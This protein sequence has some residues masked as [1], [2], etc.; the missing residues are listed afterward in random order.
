M[1]LDMTPASP[2][3]IHGVGFF[4]DACSRPTYQSVRWVGTLAL[5]TGLL[6]HAGESRAVAD[7]VRLSGQGEIRGKVLKNDDSVVVVETPSGAV[8]E[9]DPASVLFVTKRPEIVE[10]YETRA[11]MTPMN[12]KAQWDLAEWCRRNRLKDQRKQ[13]LQNVVVIEPDHKKARGALNHVQHKGQWVPRHQSMIDKGFVKH[14][15]RYITRQELELIEKSNTQIEAEKKWLKQI[16]T[17]MK[18]IKGRDVNKSRQ[19]LA[20]IKSLRDPDSIHGLARVLSNDPD[21]RARALYIEILSGIPGEKPV[22]HLV[23]QS[24]RDVKNN[25]RDMAVDAISPQMREK[26]VSHYVQSL[27][28][29]SNLV[30]R[31]AGTLLGQLGENS[32]VPQLIG[33]LVTRHRYRVRVPDNGQTISFGVDGSFGGT[34]PVL[35]LNIEI[36]LRT[37]QLQNGVIVLPEQRPVATKVVSI[38][39]SH[40]NVEVLRTLEKLTGASFGYDQR[41]WRLWWAAQRDV[42]EGNESPAAP[43]AS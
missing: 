35:P 19:T 29:P 25:I 5:L 11:K 3:S 10:S 17:W 36:L 40:Q 15:G 14:R 41:T 20:E 18:Q 24:L 32:I 8:I 42:Q 9:I 12:V 1:E 13:H 43:A 30:V 27:Y 22:E 39:H 38:T 4:G 33:A 31:R 28:D 21:P 16:R 6:S 23:N 2:R 7:I 37:G 26:A 34:G